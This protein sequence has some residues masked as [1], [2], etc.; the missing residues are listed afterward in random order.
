MEPNCSGYQIG[1][2]TLKI[3]LL[4]TPVS[5]ALTIRRLSRS[6]VRQTPL[7]RHL[8]C[9]IHIPRHAM[10]HNRNDML[11]PP[12]LLPENTGSLEFTS[13]AVLLW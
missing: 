5:K 3:S 7:A 11:T 13:A 6:A 9:N 1:P 10:R 12:L 8:S 2:V 4:Q